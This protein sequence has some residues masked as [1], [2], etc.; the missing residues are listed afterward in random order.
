MLQRIVGGVMGTKLGVK[1]AQNPNADGVVHGVILIEKD[2][3]LRGA[4]EKVGDR[5]HSAII[6][7]DLWIPKDLA[8]NGKCWRCQKSIW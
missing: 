8:R 5:G 3:P 1:V 7:R 2:L 6:E 4:G